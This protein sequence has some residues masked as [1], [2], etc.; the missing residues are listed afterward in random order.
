MVVCVLLVDGVHGQAKFAA[1]IGFGCHLDIGQ[2]HEHELWDTNDNTIHG[3]SCRVQLHQ[4]HVDADLFAKVEVVVDNLDQLLQHV[5]RG[6]LVSILMANF[7]TLYSVISLM[8]LWLLL[9]A[10]RRM[11]LVTLLPTNL[12]IASTTLSLAP[13]TN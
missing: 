9:F 12:V 8:L 5:I 3:H 1:I 6:W 4:L 13:M 11:A 7:I 10:V 2:Q